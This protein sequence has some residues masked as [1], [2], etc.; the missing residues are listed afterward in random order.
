MSSKK[1]SDKSFLS[2]G[3]KVEKS[4]I[5]PMLISQN[6]IQNAD[7]NPEKIEEAKSET[8]SEPVESV[9]KYAVQDLNYWPNQGE[10]FGSTSYASS[11]SHIKNSGNNA[12]SDSNYS[13]ITQQFGIGITKNVAAG[14][15]VQNVTSSSASNTGAQSPVFQLGIRSTGNDDTNSYFGLVFNLCPK[16]DSNNYLRSDYWSISISNA[17]NFNYSAINWKLDFLSFNENNTTKAQSSAIFSLNY[18]KYLSAEE[19]FLSIGAALQKSSNEI[20]STTNLTVKYSEPIPILRIG[21]GGSTLGKRVSWSVNYNYF[22]T[23][24]T[25]VTTVE[26]PLKYSGDTLGFSI[27]YIF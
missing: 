14:V 17:S 21:L 11:N 3:K 2:V 13:L 1:C 26:T 9:K 27:G 15:L 6:N 22:S 10:L 24:V 19:V 5:N 18:Q 12:S 23:N 25:A 20:S 7:V 8:K 16:G 4:L